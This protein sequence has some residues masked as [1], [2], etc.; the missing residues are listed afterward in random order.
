[1]NG[2]IFIEQGFDIF[3]L[4]KMVDLVQD[5]IVVEVPTE[6]AGETKFAVLVALEEWT[7]QRDMNHIISSGM[8]E[9]WFAHAQKDIV[10]GVTILLQIAIERAHVVCDLEA[11]SV[12]IL[13]ELVA[14]RL[15][16]I[17]LL[18]VKDWLSLFSFAH[19]DCSIVELRLTQVLVK[20]QLLKHSATGV[21]PLSQMAPKF[22]TC[23][24]HKNLS[25]FVRAAVPLQGDGPKWVH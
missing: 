10:N 20:H 7:V 17:S 4:T 3:A 12:N 23:Q 25:A 15:L 8:F 19:S 11:S 6:A 1:V 5:Y 13:L 24:G 22:F 2:E 21:Q 9:A 18:D 14:K 16:S